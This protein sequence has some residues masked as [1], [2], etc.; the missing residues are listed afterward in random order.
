M[1]KQ[2]DVK[3]KESTHLNKAAGELTSDMDSAKIELS[4]FGLYLVKLN[5]MEWPRPRRTKR[6]TAHP[7]LRSLDR[8]KL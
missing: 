6:G 3:Y 5:E 2:E 8:W 7:Q 4:A 1:S